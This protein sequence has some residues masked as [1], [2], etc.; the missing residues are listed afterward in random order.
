MKISATV[1][2]IFGLLANNIKLESNII[3]DYYV[4]IEKAKEKNKPIFLMFTAASCANL[5]MINELI[6]NDNEIQN[7]LN[8]FFVPVILFVDD[9]TKLQQERR[10]QRD[11]KEIK[12]RTKGN[13][14]THIEISKYNC[15]A[16]PFMLLIN[17]NEEEIKPPL[18]GNVTKSQI[19]EYL[20]M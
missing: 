19:V 11:G 20:Q 17:S 1:L 7:L 5:R 2:L 15:N 16:Q 12:I 18:I 6:N 13:E 3:H 9:K 14:W 8:Y 4:G 10:V